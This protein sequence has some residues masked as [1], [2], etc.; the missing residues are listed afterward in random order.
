MEYI[1][2]TTDFHFENTVVAL[3]KFEG[4]HKG[5]Q[6][7][8]DELNRQK[9]AHGYTSVMFTFD[10][11]PK[12][13][14]KGKRERTIYT[15][16][17]RVHKL[18]NSSL[19]VLIEHPFTKEFSRLSPEEFVK[20]VLVEKL[21]VKVIVVGFDF[22]FGYKRQGNVEV[23]QQ[24][25]KKYDYKLI[26]IPKC[27]VHG[28]KAGSTLIRKY[29]GEGNIEAANAFLDEPYSVIAAVVH[30]NAIGRSLIGLPTANIFP[31]PHKLLPPKGVYVT[32]IKLKDDVY[33]GITNIGT[34]PTVED[35]EVVG[36][37]TFIFDF[38]QDIY[39]ETIEVEFL[40]YKRPEMKFSGLDEL[41]R[42]MK[43]DAQFGREYV[44]KYF[45][46]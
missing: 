9:E 33:Y 7:L 35:Y 1:T 8:L 11:P 6:Q 2:N 45:G 18:K 12:L 10:R 23:L 36:I 21:G 16:N 3:G 39:G 26:V 42:Q 5:H 43:A 34:K 40:H 17:E 32:R 29:L 37:E 44:K 24:L 14:I 31:D 4:L 22:G 28:E 27:T 46:E 25:A 41:S 13:V 15:K 20:S 30:G 19:D 38:D